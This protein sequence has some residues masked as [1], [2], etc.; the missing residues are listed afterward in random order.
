MRTVSLTRW[1]A[2]AFASVAMVSCGGG[3]VSV[4][5]GGTHSFRGDY[6]NFILQGEFQ[7]P[8]GS[9]ACVGFRDDGKGSGYQVLLHGGPIDG[10]I[11]RGALRYVRNL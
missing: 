3:E 2:V 6:E 9:A 4:G 11:R 10:A 1:L 7:A 5:E 8:E